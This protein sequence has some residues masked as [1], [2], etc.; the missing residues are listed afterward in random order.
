VFTN[1]NLA[2]VGAML[3]TVG[4]TY[5][6]APRMFSSNGKRLEDHFKVQSKSN[7]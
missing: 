7:R 4:N 5:Q 1:G 3:A 2:L 6:K